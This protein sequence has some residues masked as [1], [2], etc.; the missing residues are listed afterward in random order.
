[1][2]HKKNVLTI[3]GS[4]SS[5]GAGIQADIK[6][7]EALNVYSASVISAITAQ[8]TLGVSSVY[9]LPAAVFSSQL[10]C[11]LSDIDFS[12]VKIGMLKSAEQ[13]H[14]V[15]EYLKKHP[16]KNIVLDTVMIS[17]SGH[18]L[19]DESATS[20]MI[21]ALFPISTLITPN[22]PEAASL[23]KKDTSWVSLHTVEACELLMHNFSLNAV[24]LKGGHAEEYF[25][26]DVLAFRTADEAGNIKIESFRYKRQPVQDT[27]GTGCT[28]SAAIAACLAQ[29]MNLIDA[30]RASGKFLQTALKNAHW[31]RTGK[32][33]GPLNHRA[34]GA[35]PA[36]GM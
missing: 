10:D 32:G 14:I 29:E 31:Q 11:V 19:Q 33:I 22:I 15:T 9:E 3:A 8:N 18:R 5:G 27:H 20:A 24:L 16:V 25:C 17:S 36:S 2:N 1:M 23:L 21:D 4:D 35:D 13:V 12:A 6:T 28:L 26:T 30:I 34:A 7:F